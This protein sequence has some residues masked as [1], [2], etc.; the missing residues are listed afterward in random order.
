[1]QTFVVF[2]YPI[3]APRHGEQAQVAPYLS[4]FTGKCL[5]EGRSDFIA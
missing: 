1:M 5:F 3:G 4:G 2:C